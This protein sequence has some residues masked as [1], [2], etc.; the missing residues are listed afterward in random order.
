MQYNLN[1]EAAISTLSSGKF[2]KYEYLTGEWILL[3][4]QSKVSEQGKFTFSA[5][6]KALEKTN[7]VNQWSR[8]KQFGALKIIK[9]VKQKLTIEDA[10]PEDR[11]NEEVKRT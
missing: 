7:K 2:D 5:W 4:N 1:R 10:C 8:K 11:L 3:S 6:R 9:T